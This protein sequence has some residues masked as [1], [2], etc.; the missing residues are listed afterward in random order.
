[1][2]HGARFSVTARQDRSVRR[3]ID[4]VAPDGWTA[5]RY[6][7]AVWDDAAQEWISDAEVAEIARLSM[8]Q[9]RTS[10]TEVVSL[11]VHGPIRGD[12]H[13]RTGWP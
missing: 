12:P 10:T 5:I 3:A 2:R 1:M 11:G 9:C 4:A 13:G 6:P 8:C 7:Q